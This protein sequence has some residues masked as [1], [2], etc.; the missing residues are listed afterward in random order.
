MV[1]SQMKTPK[2]TFSYELI[3]KEGGTEGACKV[4]KS[5]YGR[6]NL[7]GEV[8]LLLLFCSACFSGGSFTHRRHTVKADVTFM[9]SSSAAVLLDG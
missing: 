5:T 4:F 7:H 2:I 3:L 9:G 8:I 6:S 1:L